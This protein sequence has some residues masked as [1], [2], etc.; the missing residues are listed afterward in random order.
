[1]QGVNAFHDRAERR[2]CGVA[3]TGEEDRGARDA[4]QRASHVR[5]VLDVLAQRALERTAATIEAA[6]NGMPV[7][8]DAERDCSDEQGQPAAPGHL[9]GVCRQ[10]REVDRRMAAA[11]ARISTRW[12]RARPSTRVKNRTPVISIVPVTAIPYAAASRAELSN[13]AT[14]RSTPSM[15]MALTSGT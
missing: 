15:S 3:G 7:G 13:V 11:T 8:H 4:V 14:S 6:V 9:D 2:R 12:C 5:K 10:E 1:M